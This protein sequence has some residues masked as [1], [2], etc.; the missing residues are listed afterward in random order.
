MQWLRRAV[1]VAATL[2]L[3]S[4]GK[5]TI[6]GPTRTGSARLILQ[7][8]PFSSAQAVI[9]TFTSVQAHL[10]GGDFQPLPFAGG[11]TARTCDLKRLQGAQD[12][13]GT[14]PLPEGHYTQLRLT[15][16]GATLYTDHPSTG[17]ACADVVTPPAGVPVAVR[18][19]SGTITLNHQFDVT[20]G[21][22][23]TVVL[24]FDGDKSIV[25][26]GDGAYL[27]TPVMS[28]AAVR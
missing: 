15:V 7:D 22:V 28:V 12:V 26:T 4:C 5:S 9:V 16:S 8:S 11:A 13:L 24:D 3:V 17:P 21:Q 14:G 19:P 18:V 1:I 20:S 25:Q 23:T 27:M 10:A 2:A 6:T